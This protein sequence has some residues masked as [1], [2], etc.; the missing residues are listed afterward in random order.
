M[1]FLSN[2][3]QA[4]IASSGEEQL[5]WAARLGMDSSQFNKYI[6]GKARVGDA[7]LKKL[8]AGLPEIYH[9]SIIRGHLLDQLEH[10]PIAQR[11]QVEIAIRS[12]SLAEP[13]PDGLADLP[14]DVRRALRFIGHRCTERPV[15]DLVLDLARL[16]RG[17]K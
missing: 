6:N 11:N 16:L 5:S 12:Q 2:A 7:V 14:E 13:E 8:L 17:E 3:L 4:A 10:L 1:S 15:L 9:G